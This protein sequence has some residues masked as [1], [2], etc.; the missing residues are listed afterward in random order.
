MK[1]YFYQFAQGSYSDYSTGG[2]YSCDHEVSEQEWDSCYKVF[3][4]ECFRLT[5]LCPLEPNNKYCRVYDSDEMMA[6]R[7]YREQ[8]PEAAFQKLHNMVEVPYV[9]FWRD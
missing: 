3:S 8:T 2:L 4:E 9:E 6:Y 7:A 1:Q 5:Q